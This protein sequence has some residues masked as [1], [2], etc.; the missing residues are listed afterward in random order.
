MWRIINTDVHNS[1]CTV[2]Y[3][4]MIVYLYEQVFYILSIAYLPRFL[5]A[6]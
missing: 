2:V 5:I 1:I 4:H 3:M 6:L